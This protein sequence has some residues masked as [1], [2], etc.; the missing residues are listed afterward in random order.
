MKAT[1]AGSIGTLALLASG[2]M[3]TGLVTSG[4]AV[5][6]PA[7]GSQAGVTSLLNQGVKT[8]THFQQLNN[9]GVRGNATVTVRHRRLT[10]DIDARGVLKDMPHAMHIHF[11]ADS[12]HTC[13]TVWNDSNGDHRLSTSEGAPAY[14]SVKVSLTTRGAHNPGSALAVDR[15]PTASNGRI[16][17]ERTIRVRQGVARAV[18]NGE[19]AIVIHGIDYNQNGKY[20]FAGAGKSDLDPNLPAEATDPVACGILHMQKPA[21]QL[22]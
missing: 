8:Q 21:L 22:P 20:D 7:G 1:R 17:Y 9:S 5:A 13:P 6:A 10:I 2:A 12:S 14:G 3:V 11:S 15:F 16:H 4:T 18:R 19:A